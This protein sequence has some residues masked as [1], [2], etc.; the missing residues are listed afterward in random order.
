MRRRARW[1]ARPWTLPAADFPLSGS[2]QSL[3]G[4][5]NVR[6]HHRHH[7]RH[8]GGIRCPRAGWASRSRGAEGPR[9]TSCRRD[10][11]DTL[12]IHKTFGG[13]GLFVSG[14]YLPVETDSCIALD[15]PAESDSAGVASR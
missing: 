7:Y 9:S 3:T 6:G 1:K 11:T 12:R 5:A 10:Q 2:A 8:H 13:L 4:R 14:G 15:V